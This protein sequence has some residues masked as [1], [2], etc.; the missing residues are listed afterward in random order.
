MMYLKKWVNRSLY[1]VSV[2]TLLVTQQ[3]LADQWGRN[4]VFGVHSMRGY[5]AF[6]LEGSFSSAP[7]PFTGARENF[8]FSQIGRY[9]F[10]GAGRVKGEFS[11]AFQNPSSGGNAAAA[12]EIGT[13]SVTDDGRMIIE[14][15]DFR[16]NALIN[17][18]TLDCII[19]RRGRLA[20][21]MIVT[22]ISYTQGPSPVALPVTGIGSFERQR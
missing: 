5:F 1:C 9:H 21:C 8:A 2:L 13:Y 14:F 11:L 18:V 20:R 15:Q 4:G 6:T 7:P 22:L 10:D 12:I 3:A 19:V 17:E 16:G